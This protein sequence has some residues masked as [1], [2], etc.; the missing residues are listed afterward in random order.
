MLAVQKAQNEVCIATS[1]PCPII[2][3]EEYE[4]E[5]QK[6]KRQFQAQ[7]APFIEARDKV[8]GLS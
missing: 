6:L 7:Q 3:L 5:V 4:K 2:C 1:D 8:Q